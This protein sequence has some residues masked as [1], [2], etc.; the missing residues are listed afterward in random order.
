MGVVG[1]REAR[2]PAEAPDAGRLALLVDA[3]HQLAEAGLEPPAVLERL[4]RL[5]MPRLCSACHVRLL[6]AD[7]QQLESAATAHTEAWSHELMER[8]VFGHRRADEN[9]FAVVLRTGRPYLYTATELA[10]LQR[11]IP[12]EHEP[13]L[14][15]AHSAHLLVLPLRG[16]QLPLGTLS[17]Y[18]EPEAPPFDGAER[19]LLQELADRAGLALDL[20]HAYEAERRARHAAE[21]AAKRL[22]RLQRVSV[23][24]SEAL[25]PAEVVRVV[26]EEMVS[27]IGANRAVAVLPLAD[28][29]EQLELVSHRGLNPETLARLNRFPT[30]APLPV[31]MAYR[32]GEPVWLESHEALA[33]SFPESLVAWP[34]MTQAA[35]A[36]PLRT[37]GRPLG[38]IAFGFDSPRTFDT[39]ERGLM[40]DLA[41]QSAQALERACLYEAEQQARTRAERV[42]A[43]TARLQ[44][45]NA[46]LSQVLT[47]SRVA[48]VVID[49]GVAAIGAQVAGL[50]LVDESGAQLRLLHSVGLPPDV[51]GPVETLPLGH[52]TP[53]DDALERGHPVLLASH[54][55]LVRRYPRMEPQVRTLAS[56]ALPL[57]VACLPLRVDERGL[58]VLVFGFPGVHR[59]DDDERVFVTLLAHYAAQALERARLYAQERSAREALHDAH[60]TLQAIIQSSPTAINLLELDGTV[61]LWNPAAERIFGWKAEEVLGRLPP[62]VPADRREELHDNLARIARGESILGQETRRQRRDGTPIDV[63]LWS[64]A[65]QVAG[66]RRL[67]LAVVADV[68]ERRRA[69]EALRFLAEAGTVLASSLEYEVTLERVAHLAIPAYADSCSVYLRGGD[70]LVSCVATT[71][72]GEQRE[73]PQELGAPALGESTVSRVITSGQPE[74]CADRGHLAPAPCGESALPGERAARAYLCVPL[75]VRGQSIGALAFVSS[76]HSYDAQHLTLAQELARHAALAIDNARLYREARDAI[77]LRE[78]FL[79]IASHELRTP[80]TAIQLHVQELLRHLARGP[81]GIAP[82]RLRR[83]LE[84]MDRQVKRQLHLVNDLLDVSRLGV[85]QLVLRPEAMDLAALVREVAERFEPELAR[86]GS[87]LTLHAPASVPGSWDRLRLEQVVTNLVSNAVKYG[88]GNPIELRVEAGEERARLAVSDAGIGIAPEHLERV[89]GRFERAVSERH[90]GGFGLGLW[91]ARQIIETMGGHIGV[92]SQLGVGSTFRVELPRESR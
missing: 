6:S 33:T 17:I 43:R 10:E 83:G 90:Y 14:P 3:S 30:S 60:H 4:C 84:V 64:T 28:E 45:L 26:V 87:R 29:P 23:A 67:C 39:D 25:T 57:A 18:R 13:S 20:A 22:A 15:R 76:R 27:A 38:A 73:L 50:W 91:I 54:E 58:G 19:L 69:E 2:T 55:E 40:L 37:R 52:G 66:G 62:V 82:E 68:T 49:Q 65:L 36:L 9:P 34:E 35:A 41:R 80:I 1:A 11:R 70:G 16:R 8:L 78:E 74:L 89:F 24:L 72:A 71:R 81:E 92:S 63:S 47:A 46:A 88:Q 12:P 79:S 5:V 53:L 51:T 85:G 77:R 31:A 32:T 42:A 59:F 7:G 44:T 48:E 61:R 75:L 21:V 86:T 56:P